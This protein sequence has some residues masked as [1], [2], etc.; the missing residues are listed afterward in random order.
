MFGLF[1]RASTPGSGLRGRTFL[2]LESLEWRDQ[3]SDLTLVVIE[4]DAGQA[5]RP[6][7]QAPQIVNFMAH[8]ITN[9]LFLIT[10][11][12]VDESPGGLTVTLAGSTA[13]AGQTVTTNSDGTFSMTLQ[14]PVDGTGSGYLTA[15]VRDA[16]GLVSEEV[17]VFLDPTIP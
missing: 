16:Q 7:N 15:T 12:V 17:S 9:G 5:S 4:S 11:K 2:R 10:G 14:L 1:R 8:E 6:Q 3:P 13:G